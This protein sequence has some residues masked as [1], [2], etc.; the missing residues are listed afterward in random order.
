MESYSSTR[1]TFH[2]F[3]VEMLERLVRLENAMDSVIAAA[4]ARSATASIELRVQIIST[5]PLQRRTKALKS[6]MAACGLTD[7][8]PYVIPIIEEVI[9]VRNHM[10]HSLDDETV[11]PGDGTIRL[12]GIGSGRVAPVSYS[13]E[14]LEWLSAQA[15]Q[16]QRE[17]DE[18]Y[19]RIAPADPTWHEG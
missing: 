12:L 10:A 13:S 2:R 8:Y 16:V 9:R 4:F 3:R 19:W 15:R 14:F 7:T 1:R 17:L 11:D 18:M 5:M 6:V